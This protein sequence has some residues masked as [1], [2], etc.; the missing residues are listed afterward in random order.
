[1]EDISPPEQTKSQK[2]ENTS[3]EVYTILGGGWK[4]FYTPVRIVTNNNQPA[5]SS[6]NPPI[7]PSASGENPPTPKMSVLFKN[8][9][10]IDVGYFGKLEFLDDQAGFSELFGDNP[11]INVSRMII[12]QDYTSTASS[13]Y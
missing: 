10:N 1:M 8:G 2:S 12:S 7:P 5:G 3:G 4:L 11:K 13:L 9:N 6:Q